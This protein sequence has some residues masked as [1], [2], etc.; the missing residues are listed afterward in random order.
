MKN[1]ILVS[2]MCSAFAS[3]SLSASAIANNDFTH[4]SHIHHNGSAP[5]AVTL[6]YSDHSIGNDNETVVLNIC[7]R[8]GAANIFGNFGP[9]GEPKIVVSPV[10]RLPELIAFFANDNV[11][12]TLDSFISSMQHVLQIE[13]TTR[14]LT[15]EAMAASLRP[16]ELAQINSKILDISNEMQKALTELGKEHGLKALGIDEWTVKMKPSKI[17]PK[18][19]MSPAFVYETNDAFMAR[20]ARAEKLIF[21]ENPSV[22]ILQEVERG[23]T[24]AEKDFEELTK[25]H[26]DYAW[27]SAL[28]ETTQNQEIRNT[29]FTSVIGYRTDKFTPAVD[30][31]ARSETIKQ[32]FNK[33]FFKDNK[34][35]DKICVIALRNSSNPLLIK[36]AVNVHGDYN[37]ANKDIKIYGLLR[38]LFNT[39]PGLEFG[40][41]LNAQVAK[42][43]EI[44]E[45][46]HGFKGFFKIWP[47]PENG[48][49]SNPTSDCLIKSEYSTEPADLDLELSQLLQEAT[50]LNTALN[51]PAKK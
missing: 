14:K 27:T 42:A 22:V 41:D 43:P 6:P 13:A 5:N 21:E 40:A 20:F 29:D 4:S 44:Q 2:L 8:P 24:Y 18:G 30:L 36:Y 37:M 31:S 51:A 23:G 34:S 38:K 25:R 39:L 48:S 46:F 45:Q 32:I 49:G 35:L 1:K 17:F 28:S 9:N 50:N 33:L 19:I 15:I 3:V 47:T 7:G 12:L 11:K 10:Y 26:P 16:E